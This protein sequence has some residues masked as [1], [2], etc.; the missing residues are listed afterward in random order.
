M[1]RTSI[2][3]IGRNPR[4]APVSPLLYL[5][6]VMGLVSMAAPAATL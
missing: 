2:V 6:K 1:P 3:G 5:S 4:E